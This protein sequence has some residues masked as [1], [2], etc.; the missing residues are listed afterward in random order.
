MKRNVIAV[1]ILVAVVTTAS[2][3]LSSGKWTVVSTTDDSNVP[4][5]TP[6]TAVSPT[7]DDSNVAT[8]P[9]TP[10]VPTKKLPCGNANNEN[11]TPIDIW[12]R[13]WDLQEYFCQRIF[14]AVV[15]S[16]PTRYKK[17]NNKYLHTKDDFV[18]ASGGAASGPLEQ[19]ITFC[20]QQAKSLGL[21]RADMTFIDIGSNLAAFSEPFARRGFKVISFEP[22][23]SNEFAHRSTMCLFDPKGTA[24][25]WTYFNVGLG[26]QKAICKV[27]SENTNIGDGVTFCSGETIPND[28]AM[29]P[30]GTINIERLD[31]IID[32]TE[33][34]LCP[35]K[36]DVENYEK[37]L[38]MGGL[39][40]FSSPKVKYILGEFYMDAPPPYKA[41][42]PLDEA[43][44][45]NLWVF[46]K[47]KELGYKMS[48]HGWG[49]VELQAIPRTHHMDNLFIWRP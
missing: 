26:A 31:D 10:L 39:K 44:A 17:E 8:P 45:R 33:I 42:V 4:T 19:M 12:R 36:V 30:R 43:Y 13:A 47:Y 48:G 9:I 7:T 21:T 11:T 34:N 5:S 37:F 28:A 2:V 22:M 3:V 46:N 41:K 20:D 16:F 29:S 1:A 24:K 27:F 40:F 38:M 23:I 35:V 15:D 25:N 18:S 6:I 32:L 49:Q 14:P